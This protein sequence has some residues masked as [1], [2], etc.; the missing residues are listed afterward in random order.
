LAQA[1]CTL[2]LDQKVAIVGMWD[3]SRL[4]Q[5]ITNLLSNAVKFGKNGPISVSSRIRGRKAELRVRDSGI[6]IPPERLPHIFDRF[7]RAAP[8]ESYAGLGLGLFIVRSIVV[9]HGGTV[10]AQSTPGE[11]T[12]M[13]VQLPLEPRL[14]ET[15]SR[16][17]G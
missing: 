3:K 15:H 10:V 2:E 6:G 8:S 17:S 11:G 1:N 9:A 16:P 4:D 5:V 7:E 14:D 13:T 12:T